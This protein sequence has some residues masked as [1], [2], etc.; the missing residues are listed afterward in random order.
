MLD[1]YTNTITTIEFV[2]I[3][4]IE[5]EHHCFAI[6]IQI[7][8][9]VSLAYVPKVV[10]KRIL[11]TLGHGKDVRIRVQFQPPFLGCWVIEQKSVFVA[12]KAVMAIDQLP[13]P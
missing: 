11:G 3:A 13:G 7:I 4:S 12:A 10:A 9:T 1:W 2:V 8:E 5:I 6:F